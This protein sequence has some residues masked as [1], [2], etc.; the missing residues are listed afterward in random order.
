M[1]YAYV[2]TN[3]LDLWTEPKFNSERA[4]QL[5]F[6]EPLKIEGEQ[7]DNYVKAAGPDGYSGWVDIRHIGEISE[8]QHR[9]Q[10]T[11]AISV[12]VLQQAKIFA[13]PGGKPVAPYFLFYGTKVQIGHLQH[14]LIEIRLPD[15]DAVF[16]KANS[17]QEIPGQASKIGGSTLVAEAKKYLG[18]PYLW[19]GISP[20]GFDCSGFTQTICRRFGVT[21]PRDTKDQITVGQEVDRDKMKTGDLVFF[22]RHVGFAIGNDAIIHASVGG[23][24]V[25]IN[26]IAAGGPDYRED[27]DRDYN[28]ARRIV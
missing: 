6:A 13:G 4:S 21:I 9:A 19:G 7:S 17:L 8:E 27:L 20:A 14:G 1:T 16:T 23:G 12:I 3:L 5:F 22:K 15:G 26:S 24:G 10:I 25:R 28:Q 11:R 18:V 2:K